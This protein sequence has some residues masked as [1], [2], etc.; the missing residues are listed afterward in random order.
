MIATIDYGMGNVR[1]IMKAL[2]Y[3]GYDAVLTSNAREIDNASHLILPG[4]GAF[5]DAIKNITERGLDLILKNQILE[6]GKPFLGVCLGLQLLAKSSEEHGYHQGLGILDAKV[7]KFK[8]NAIK[9]NIPH[10]GWNDICPQ[11]DHFLFRKLQK[12]HLT[13]YFVHSYH[14]VCN[15]PQDIL[16]TCD[17]GIVFTAAIAHDNILA[18]QFH[19]EKS[20]DNGIQILKNFLSWNP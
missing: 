2:K 3:I 10:I 7:V 17:Y 13:F 1:S 14:I 11:K 19:P 16:A 9:L 12:N 4:V 5:G 8:F 6:K 18:T 15:Q 20:Q